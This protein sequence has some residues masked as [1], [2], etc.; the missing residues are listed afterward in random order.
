M[1]NWK[2]SDW[3]RVK[4]EYEKEHSKDSKLILKKTGC[5]EVG[6]GKWDH[7]YEMTPIGNGIFRFKC[8]VCGDEVRV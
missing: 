5:M 3:M 8:R 2:K 1:S 6:L 4:E 7:T